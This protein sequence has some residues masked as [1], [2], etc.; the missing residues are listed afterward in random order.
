[1]DPNV[2]IFLKYEYAEATNLA[3]SFL[4]L[5]AAILVFSVTFSERVVGFQTAGRS[6]RV[7]LVTSWSLIFISIITCGVAI[8]FFY[9]SDV[10]AVECG[11]APC[12]VMDGV[13]PPGYYIVRYD[14]GNLLMGAAGVFFVLGLLSL[15]I[16]ALTSLFAHSQSVSGESSGIDP[17]IEHVALDTAAEESPAPGEGNARRAGAVQDS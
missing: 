11:A 10:L 16:S 9:N 15:I 1:M 3:K 14:T 2:E 4:T 8:V 7:L 12:A 13:L 17:Q 6:S 5:I